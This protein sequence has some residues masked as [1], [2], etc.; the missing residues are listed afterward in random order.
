MK[1]RAAS[2]GTPRP[3]LGV[4]IRF[5]NSAATLPGVLEALR[6]QT[7]RPDLIVGV[8]NQSTDASPELMRAAGARIVDWNEPYHHSR[9]LN[10]GLRQCPTELVLVLSSHTVFKSPDAIARLVAAM[11]DPKTACASV[12]WD[13]DLFYSEAVE[14]RELQQKG[15]KFGSIYSNS[16][17]LLRRSLW[18]QLPFDETLASMEDCAWALEQV[19]RGHICRRLKLPFTYQRSGK[20]RAFLFA[21][22][23]FKL[24]A[25]HGLTVTWLGPRLTMRSMA[26]GVTSR[27]F[28]QPKAVGPKEELRRHRER[29][30]AWLTWR[31]RSLPAT[32]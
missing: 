14:W 15:L 5:R 1:Q 22:I 23:T 7:V 19:K 25:R 17:G 3:S 21:M 16:M 9:V 26:R 32:E 20:D 27:L 8:N 11:R 29:F 2:P 31:W 10:F 4:L 18:E 13:D 24:A 30:W 6:R 12:R 28:A